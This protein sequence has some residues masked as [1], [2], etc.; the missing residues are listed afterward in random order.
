MFI[1]SSVIV[2]LSICCAVILG[3]CFWRYRSWVGAGL[4][5]PVL[6]FSMVYVLIDGFPLADGLVLI[7]YGLTVL[8]FGMVMVFG[9]HLIYKEREKNGN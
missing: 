2:F 7:R 4:F 1:P 8:F 9:R 5:F 3:V 6:Y